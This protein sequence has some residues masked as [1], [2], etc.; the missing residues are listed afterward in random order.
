MGRWAAWLAGIPK[1]IHTV[2]G[3]G[4]HEHQ[5]WIPWIIHYSCELFTSFVTTHYICVSSHDI[6][7]GIRRFPRFKN[8]HSLIRAAV[9]WEP[10]FKPAYTTTLP[11][12]RFI[13][14]TVACFKP[15]KNLFDL[16]YAFKKVYDQ[17][18]HVRLEIIGDGILRPE[19]ESWITRNNLSDVITL[20]G[21]Q[22]TVAPYLHTWDAFVLSSLWEGLPC[23]VVEA[24]L[25]H[26]P[27]LAYNTG[28]IKDII[29]HEKNGLLYPQKEW[30]NLADG[31]LTVAR[32]ANYAHK[33]QNYTD[34]LTEFR[35]EAMI[36]NHIQ[37]YEKI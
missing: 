37:L 3:F 36:N 33:L 20:H 27:V 12:D 9:D 6:Q 29:F 24:R 19:I 35:A 22:H 15:Q 5:S 16:L 21:W 23:A 26:L 2:H 11:R 4:F 1:R 7:T 30:Y 18:P 31:M 17:K 25:C 34:N 14:G 10:F 32:D 28:G 8:R 13:F